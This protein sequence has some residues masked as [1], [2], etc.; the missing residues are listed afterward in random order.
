M[1]FF[2]LLLVSVCLSE[3]S[4]TLLVLFCFSVVL[5][6]LFVCLSVCLYTCLFVCLFVSLSVCLFV[7]FCVYLFVCLFVCVLQ[8][9]CRPQHIHE[10]R[11]TPYS[12]YAAVSVGLQVKG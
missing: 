10:F 6:C 7:C 12:L 3:L 1:F 2:F 5:F 11:L 4:L 8:P 9:V